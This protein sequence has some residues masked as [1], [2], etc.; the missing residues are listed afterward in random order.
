[1]TFTMFSVVPMP[2]FEWKKENMRYM[3]CALPLVGVVIG[4]CLCL[5]AWIAEKLR[6]G[7]FLYAVGLTL[8]PVLLSGGIHVDGFLD[9]AD[10]L[11]SH[12]T[13]EK[14]REIL[15]D[16]HTG[17]FAVIFAVCYFLLYTALCSET[18]MTVRAALAL[19][20]TH[21]FARAVGA[22][23][24]TAFPGSGSTGLLSTFRDAAAKRAGAEAVL[25]ETCFLDDPD[26]MAL[27]LQKKNAVVSAI[28]AALQTAFHLSP[29]RKTSRE[30]VQEAA[31]LSDATMRYLENYRW[32]KEL[33]DKLA[34]AINR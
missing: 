18:D 19:G 17:A 12:A 32:G 26:D 5:W 33:L 1:M 28:A 10:A 13:P 34:A 8:L 15:K 9:T 21:V 20:L 29:R 25:L 16:S 3:L 27:Y 7:A 6:L 4:A 11:S 2:Q 31:G 22:L 24:S 30:I 14:K 23:A